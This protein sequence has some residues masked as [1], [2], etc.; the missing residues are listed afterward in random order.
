MNPKNRRFL[1]F[2]LRFFGVYA[3]LSLAYASY[4]RWGRSNAG[5]LDPFSIKVG[6][7]AAD[8][9][10]M[11]G[12][13]VDF[14]PTLH[15]PSY[16]FLREGVAVARMVEGCN[17]VAVVILFWA[18]LVAFKGSWKRT[19]GYGLAG[20]LVILILNCLRIALLIGLLQRF[21]EHTHLLHG[22]VFPAMIYGTVFLLWVL[23]VNNFAD[24]ARKNREN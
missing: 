2:L 5:V 4:L 16:T 22:V 14:V 17:A 1:A 7:I 23:W 13:A 10:K 6:G 8:G 18:F 12:P 20:T 9:A 19:I 24:Y 3:V 11:F 21:P 15:E